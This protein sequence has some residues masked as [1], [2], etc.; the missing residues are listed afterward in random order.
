MIDHEVAANAGCGQRSR[1]S[2]LILTTFGGTLA[3]HIIKEKKE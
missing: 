1:E 3:T 2:G